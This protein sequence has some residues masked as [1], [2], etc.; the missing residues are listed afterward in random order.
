[1]GSHVI[2]IVARENKMVKLLSILLLLG[3]CVQIDASVSSVCHN[4]YVLSFP[5]VIVPPG[6]TIPPFSSSFTTPTDFAG[7]WL[8][9][10]VLV[11]GSVNM[12]DEQ[13][14]GFFDDILIQAI[15][16]NGQNN[17]VLW[18]VQGAATNT[19]SLNI[20]ASNANLLNYIDK[21]NNI[22]TEILL[23]TQ[24]P[25]TN[26]WSIDINLCVSAE[27]NKEYTF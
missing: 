1:M 16:P 13:T 21:D 2:V 27:V 5:S 18:D 24:H 17:L 20:N 15:D 8:T 19:A 22:T 7:D 3:G 4:N 10:V 9:K 25:P 11:S 6:T 12:E 23:S 26:T 14:F